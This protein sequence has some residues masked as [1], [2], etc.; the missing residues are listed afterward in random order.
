MTRRLTWAGFGILA[1]LV[2]MAAGHLVAA[3]TDPAASPVLTVGSTV[4][5]LTPTPLKEWAIRTFGSSDKA[6]LVGSVMLGALLLAALAGLLARR[7]FVLGAGVLVLLVASAAAMALL[8]PGAAALDVLPA[9]AAGVV[10][11]AALALL[12]RSATREGGPAQTDGSVQGPSRRAVLITAGALTATA[13]VFAGA[14]QWVTGRRTTPAG[15]ALPKAADPA[16]PLPRDLRGTVPG[17]SR[18]QTA[19]GDFYRVDTRLTLPI[20]SLDDW[21]LTIDGDVDHEVTLTYD[22]LLAMP[23][24]ERDITLT[25][26][27][28]DIGGPYVGGA[29]WLGVR[30]SDLLDRAGVGRDAD[31][32]FSRDVDG[33]TISTPLELA[34]AQ[35]DAMLAIGMNG[36]PL[37]QEHGF[38]ARL[39]IPGLY[40]F[41]SATKW[42]T[43][44]TLTTYDEKKAYWTDRGWATEAPIKIASRIDT[45]QSFSTID[46]GDTFIGGVAWAQTRGIGKVEVQVDGSAWQKAELGPQVG[47]DYW[48]QWYFPWKAPPGEHDLSVRATDLGGEVQTDA[49]AAPFPNGSS[50]RQRIIVTVG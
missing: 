20:I 49:K 50:G 7:R 39:V 25:C 14:G 23:L 42:I 17:I 9:I 1:T 31:Q 37:P 22:D 18:L 21:T 15:V 33:M 30:L 16:P 10:G 3:V 40:G 34:M 32:I 47:V 48:R 5:D 2:G 45:P 41:I 26:V 6:V 38:P 8:R 43:R 4:I 11:V 19:T 28:N 35:K 27:S 13:A 29:R 46:A 44:M 24:I 12:S 36:E